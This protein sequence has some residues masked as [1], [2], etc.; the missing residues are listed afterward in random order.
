MSVD[1]RSGTAV[2]CVQIERTIIDL[3][4]SNGEEKRDKEAT[5]G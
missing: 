5:F 4:L 2:F 1:G 3:G